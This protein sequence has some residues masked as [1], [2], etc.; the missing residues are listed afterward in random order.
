MRALNGQRK[1]SENPIINRRGNGKV[2]VSAFVCLVMRCSAIRVP[3]WLI[4]Y[5]FI[6]CM[7]SSSAAAGK[8][9]KMNNLLLSISNVLTYLPTNNVFGSLTTDN[10]W[11]NTFSFC[12][13]EHREN[14]FFRNFIDST[15][16]VE[17]H[18][19]LCWQLL[20]TRFVSSLLS[21]LHTG[22]TMITSHPLSRQSTVCNSASE[23]DRCLWVTAMCSRV[24]NSV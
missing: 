12:A 23:P 11:T 9:E 22:A 13:F 4:K 20:H 6:D 7:H 18:T 24:I 2:C 10:K 17:R 5:S 16:N 1:F 21:Y 19:W 3:H 15:Q 8:W 14:D